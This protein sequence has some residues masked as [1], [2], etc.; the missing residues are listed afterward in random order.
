[1]LHT[2]KKTI[3][4]CSS[5]LIQLT[6]TYKVEIMLSFTVNMV[7]TI[8][9]KCYVI[10]QSRIARINDLVRLTS[11]YMFL[12]I[13]ENWPINSEKKYASQDAIIYTFLLLAIHWFFEFYQ[14]S[15]SMQCQYKTMHTKY[16]A[17]FFL[18]YFFVFM[19]VIVCTVDKYFYF[20]KMFLISSIYKQ[21]PP[22]VKLDS[23]N[24]LDDI[25]IYM[26]KSM[27]NLK[28]EMFFV[29]YSKS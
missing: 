11:V 12:F 9:Q 1:M 8:G 18:C 19:R 15:W 10:F 21:Q 25:T 7:N 2:K 17:T 28:Y 29:P 23:T 20:I 27:T 3:S 4:F 22:V 16:R 14:R 5:K 6:W 24:L 13:F 26:T